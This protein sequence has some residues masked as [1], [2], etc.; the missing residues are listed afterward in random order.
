MEAMIF[1][2]L[3]FHGDFVAR[4]IGGEDR[5]TLDD[6]LSQSMAEAHDRLGESFSE[7]F[8]MA[9]PWLFAWNDEGTWTAG[10]LAPSVDSAGRRFPIIA[11][12]RGLDKPLAPAAAEQ[13]EE[14]L[15]D[16]VSN[17]WSAD[18]LEARIISVD[19]A[20]ATSQVEQGWWS[21]DANHVSLRDRFPPNLLAHVVSTELARPS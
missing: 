1:G 21:K 9:S 2:K 8:D 3:P 6:W 20:P 11:G 14:A 17:R 4:G 15:F 7:A 19:L 18:Q 16:A 5:A 12:L 13:C 10:A